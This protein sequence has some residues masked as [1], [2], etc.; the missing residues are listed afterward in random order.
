[1]LPA[2]SLFHFLTLEEAQTIRPG[3]TLYSTIHR[4]SD[5]TPQRWRTNGAP[6]LWKRSPNR[7]RLPLKYGLRNYDTL[8]EAEFTA[9]HNGNPVC[10]LLTLSEEFAAVCLAG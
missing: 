2:Y 9:Q 1:M 5:G 3:T 7:V 8:T 4:N 6:K 10:P